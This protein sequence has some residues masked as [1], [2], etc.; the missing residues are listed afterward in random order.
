MHMRQE[1]N[2][3][4]Q[5]ERWKCHISDTQTVRIVGTITITQTDRQTNRQEHK[6]TDKLVDLQTGSQIHRQTG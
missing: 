3:S 5:T 6:H 2:R 1:V 4:R